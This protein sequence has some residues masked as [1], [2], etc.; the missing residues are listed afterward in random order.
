MSLRK[1]VI[2]GLQAIGLSTA[3]IAALKL[4]QL[5]VLARLLAPESFGVMAMATVVTGMLA[6]FA[7]IGAGSVVVH[8]QKMANAE[9]DALF[10]LGLGVGVVAAALVI[11]SSTL[12]AAHFREPKLV[13]VLFILSGTLV[14]QPIGQP[15]RSLLERG[16]VFRA[17]AIAEGIGALSG[18]AIAIGT[19]WGGAGVL[20]LAWGALAGTLVTTSLYLVFGRNLWR[21]RLVFSAQQFRPNFLF[22]ARLS[23][24][25][26]LNYAAGNA[27]F[28]LIGTFLGSQALGYY[29]IAYN[30]ANLA[31]SH[32]N[33]LLSRVAFPAMSQL[34]GGLDRLRDAYLKF[35]GVSGLVNFPIMF[36]LAA[37]ADAAI[38]AA[39]GG[40]WHAAIPM[41]QVLCLVG[42]SRSIAGTIGPLLLAGG[43]PDLGL[44][45]SLIVAAIQVPVLA[46][47]LAAGDA[48]GVAI[49]FALV[50]VPLLVFNYRYL[51]R[52]LIGPCAAAYASVVALPLIPAIAAGLAIYEA[53]RWMGTSAPGTA[54]PLVAAQVLFG[55]IVYGGAL[56][57]FFPQR[58]RGAFQALRV[59]LRPAP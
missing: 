15:F 36:G 16:L 38:P 57:L 23:G 56:F 51:V 7:E 49:A 35:Q 20:S 3:L 9:L 32:V 50:Q 43:R 25:R 12:V 55:A 59:W 8:R 54:L 48:L 44:R 1:R 31:S 30:V 26:L 22:G 2:D 13:Q 21:P 47:G 33:G 34:Q 39:L 41:L 18:A 24:Q 11:A 37:I 58:T 27:D 6:H 45:W 5:V 19:A 4:L 52:A 29:A 42:L 17:V 28:F 14:L 46:L 10:W 53:G 40:A